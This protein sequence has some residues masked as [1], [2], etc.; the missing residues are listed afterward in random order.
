MSCFC[1]GFVAVL[2]LA[3]GVT[4]ISATAGGQQLVAETE[5]LEVR[6]VARRVESGRV[7]FAMQHVGGS[8]EWGE[9]MLPARRFFPTSARVGRWLSSSPLSIDTTPATELRIA[10]RRLESGGIEFGLQRRGSDG[11][12]GERML[13][14]RRSFPAGAAAGRWLASSPVTVPGIEWSS[15]VQS[16]DEREEDTRGHGSEAIPSEGSFSML[17][18]SR[19]R[20]CAVRRDG[21][22]SCWGHNR[23][24]DW[25]STAPLDGVAAISVFGD[26]RRSDHS[27]VLH[28]DGG[29][30]C[31][32]EGFFGKLGLGQ[33]VTP[34]LPARIPEL[35]DAVAVSVGVYHSCVLHGDGGVSCWGNNSSG[36]IGDGSR[37]H[38]SSP[39]RVVGL[40]DVTSI[41]SGNSTNCAVHGTG[42][43]S[44][45]GRGFDSVPRSLEGLESV[46]SVAV[47]QNQICLVTTDGAVRCG[48]FGSARQPADV[49]GVDDAVDVSMGDH[50]ICALHSHGGVSCWGTDNRV[51]QLGDGTTIAHSLPR[52]VRDIV[53]AVQV[54]VSRG[55]PPGETHAC[56]LHEGGAISCWGANESGQLGDGTN[57]NRLV[58]TL[59]RDSPAT[60]PD[61]V[62]EDPTLLMRMWGDRV[63]EEFE[64]DFPWL[65][66]AWDYAR[67]LTNVYDLEWI[68]RG[69]TTHVGTSCT[70][71]TSRFSCKLHSI[72]VA[73]MTLNVFVHELAHAYDRTP[74]LAPAKAWGAVQVY[75][76]VTFPDCLVHQGNPLAAEL[77][78][79][80]MEHLV[81]PDGP[82]LYHAG[83]SQPTFRAQENPNYYDYS[84]CS[85]DV[86]EPSA[87]TE[88]IVLAG[89]AGEVPDWF[90]ENITDGSDL[91]A[92]FLKAPSWQI[93]INL[94]DEFGGL[95]S[96]GWVQDWV[97]SSEEDPRARPGPPEGSNPFRDGGC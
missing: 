31:W 85:P 5:A 15:G 27:C 4:A 40:H 94:A 52:R 38:R 54:K 92:A 76:A 74:G 66:V 71:G 7:E 44:C 29:V 42:S 97:R 41:A 46:V 78:A 32:G 80:T 37:Q 95:C 11:E 8:G 87:L 10:A 84:Q 51:G 34:F 17:D 79:E 14:K 60:N 2:V 89:L 28:E 47:G 64:T 96:T 9:R 21:G 35:T 90:T 65:R 73:R 77:L 61:E 49:E 16:R 12:W 6:I 81:L 56:A 59:A 24:H 67:E 83:T 13:P 57:E 43:V 23:L 88:G 33:D 68:L 30:S 72:W 69:K 82:L 3:A 50:S 48:G 20:T 39:Q 93:L 53:D 58:P 86:A 19:S 63:V 18:A 70:Y 45:W 75:F 36:Q 62:P 26:Y 22:V 1:R 55:A 25:L 91:W